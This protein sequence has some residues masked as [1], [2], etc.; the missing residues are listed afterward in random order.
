[1][2]DGMKRKIYSAGKYFHTSSI[3]HFLEPN[4]RAIWRFIK[5][6]PNLS[7]SDSGAPDYRPYFEEYRLSRAEPDMYTP[8]D[9]YVCVDEKD[10]K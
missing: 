8:L 1:M 7:L 4:S 3:H 5:Q 6:Q 9:L 2:C 10:E